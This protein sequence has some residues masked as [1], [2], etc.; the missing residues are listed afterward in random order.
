MK[1]KYEPNMKESI[2]M[3]AGGTGI[4]PM[5]QVLEHILANP[6]DRTKVHLVFANE[7]ERDILLK[8]RLDALAKTHSGS[9]KARGR[10]GAL[11]RSPLRCCLCP[12][13]REGVTAR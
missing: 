5:L 11:Q 4:T 12:R 2:G 3:V 7:E 8:P 1:I 9:F 10:R 6:N 13:G